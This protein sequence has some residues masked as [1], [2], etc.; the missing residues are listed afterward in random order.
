MPAD[1]LSDASIVLT[2]SDI[3][4]GARK[5]SAAL[6]RRFPIWPQHN[7][8][9]TGRSS[10]PNADPGARY[11]LAN[12]VLQ[13][14][15]VLGLA[16]AGFVAGL[17]VAGFRFAGIAGASAGAIVAMGMA[18]IRGSDMLRETHR[19]IA[20]IIGA[21]PMDSFVD[22]PAGIRRLVKQFAQ[23]RLERGPANWLAGLSALGR[24]LWRR[25]INPGDAF[26]RWL[27][28]VL[29]SHGMRSV[30]E[31]QSTQEE[32][33]KQL[34]RM[35]VL[36]SGAGGRGILQ[37]TAACVPAGV[38]FHF[39][40]DVRFLTPSVRNRSPAALVRASMSIPLFFEPT[41]FRVDRLEF[42][43]L[44]EN[45]LGHFI[46]QK[47]LRELQDLEEVAFL[48]GGIFSNLPLDAFDDILPDVPTIVAPLVTAPSPKPFLRRTRLRS[49]A[50]DIGAV[51][52]MV[53]N[54]R[55]HDAYARMRRAR[56]TRGRRRSAGEV[57]MCAID[58]G[59]SDWLNFAMQ[60][61]EQKRLFR[62][63]LERAAKFVTTLR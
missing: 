58:V 57:I 28:R 20:Q 50:A 26:E 1:L 41:F 39:P 23:G 22:G 48:D 10:R 32:L 46:G 40:D 52:F 43:A 4:E 14:G 27:Q 9:G 5:N 21:M 16:H 8:Q 33:S 3:R 18:A 60:G 45:R 62:C 44:I 6:K 35:G 11:R 51:A 15:G 36:K 63:G 31:L 30:A 37:I 34:K 19:E 61:S 38:K 54:Q 49:L 25:G 12:V 55:D 2:L 24:I 59:E 47:A 17:E 56:V 13:G 29:D 53:R 7:G 42:P